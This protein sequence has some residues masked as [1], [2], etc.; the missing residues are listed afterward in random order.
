MRNRRVRRRTLV[1]ALL[2]MLAMASAARSAAAQAPVFSPEDT[3]PSSSDAARRD[4][5][6]V[7]RQRSIAAS[8]S[9]IDG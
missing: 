2:A 1:F 8:S 3:S 7:V 4:L 9:S 6:P 5:E